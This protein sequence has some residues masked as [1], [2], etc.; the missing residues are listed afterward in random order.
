MPTNLTYSD[1][2]GDYGTLVED[3]TNG[4]ISRSDACHLDPDINIE[5]LSRL[6]GWRGALGQAGAAQSHLRKNG[7]AI[8]D[9]FLFWGLFREAKFDGRWKF[10]GP[11]E[12][13]LFGWLQVGE[14]IDLGPDG[15][16]IL[17]RFPWLIDHP[18]VR[19]GWNKTNVLYIAN[20]RLCV[21]GVNADYSGWGTFNKSFKL[22]AEGHNCSV[23]CMP[24]WL[25]PKA[26]GVGMTY[27]P[28][29][30][31]TED[32]QLTTAARGQEFVAHVGRSRVARSWL[33]K[34]FGRCA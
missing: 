21:P 26:G 24:K 18:H 10:V 32:D 33:N 4:R 2:R 11:R 6:K 8:N 15:Q 22:T 12:H 30:R 3:L 13:R 9:I 20:E 34:L 14:I 5:S 23:W 7:I 1:L 27:H 29:E 28:L 25:N 16:Y 31:W 17:K 19:S